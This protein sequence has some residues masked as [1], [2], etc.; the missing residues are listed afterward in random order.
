[1]K[2]LKQSKHCWAQMQDDY[3]S[4][5]VFKENAELKEHKGTPVAFMLCHYKYDENGNK[6]THSGNPF[7]VPCMM[8]RKHKYKSSCEDCVHQ[9]QYALKGT[10]DKT[11]EAQLKDV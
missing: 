5:E 7:C 11:F 1:M 3:K 8:V 9:H 6:L 10:C 2:K 4:R